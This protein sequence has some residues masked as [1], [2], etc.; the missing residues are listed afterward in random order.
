MIYRI[1]HSSE[2]QVFAKT[3]EFTF[4]HQGSKNTCGREKETGLL[5]LSASRASGP[6]PEQ[7]VLSATRLFR[8]CPSQKLCLLMLH[9]PSCF[10]SFA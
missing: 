9:R 3:S 6:A 1:A 5:Q 4:F 8:S 7:G 2:R 10:L